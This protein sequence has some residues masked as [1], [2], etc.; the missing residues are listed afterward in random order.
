[1]KNIFQS[2][3]LVGK[4]LYFFGLEHKCSSFEYNKS[5]KYSKIKLWNHFGIDPNPNLN[6]FYLKNNKFESVPNFQMK[7]SY[8]NMTLNHLMHLAKLD[9][10]KNTKIIESPT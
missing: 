6:F 1:M 3:V 10:A 4:E 2:S 9:V 7:S 5:K 8:S